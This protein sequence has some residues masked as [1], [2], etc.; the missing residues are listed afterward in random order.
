MRETDTM[1]FEKKTVLFKR[2]ERFCKTAC[3][4]TIKG[5]RHKGLEAPK[6]VSSRRTKGGIAHG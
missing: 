2:I 6:K 1:L 5:A 4:A 3:L